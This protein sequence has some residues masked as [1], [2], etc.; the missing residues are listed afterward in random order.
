MCL[1]KFGLGI[2]KFIIE[3]EK[4]KLMDNEVQGRLKRHKHMW[5]DH[6]CVCVCTPKNIVAYIFIFGHETSISLEKQ[7]TMLRKV[8]WDYFQT[9]TIAH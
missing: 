9:K 6:V 2:L 1:D 4:V 5:I 7:N 8:S 3:L